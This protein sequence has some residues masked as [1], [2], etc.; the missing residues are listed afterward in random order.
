MTN[1]NI[2]EFRYNFKDFFVE[3][4]FSSCVESGFKAI[5][6]REWYRC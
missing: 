6:V 2:N 1:E 4:D 5:E 3:K